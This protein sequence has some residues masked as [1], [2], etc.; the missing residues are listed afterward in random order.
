MTPSRLLPRVTGSAFL[1]CMV[2]CGSMLTVHAAPLYEQDFINNSGANAAVNTVGW[3]AYLGSTATV[4]SAD[5]GGGGVDRIG[6]SYLAGNPNT[7][8]GYLY[9]A[10]TLTANQIFA[11]TATFSSISPTTITWREGNNNTG[12]SVRLMVQ[13]GGSWYATDQ[14]FS[15]TVAYST[16]TDFSNSSSPDVMKSFNFTTTASSWRS[17]TLVPG[18]TLSLGSVLTSDLV[19]SSITGIGFF[20]QSPSTLNVASRLDTLVIVPE[21]QTPILIGLGLIGRIFFH[22]RGQ[23]CR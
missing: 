19:S 6:I 4:K 18:S 22:R 20:V 1:M 9:T 15:N 2:A 12:I 11:A 13:V 21:P 16:A 8:N 5:A 14:A 17:V 10:N 3:N 7:S 23:F